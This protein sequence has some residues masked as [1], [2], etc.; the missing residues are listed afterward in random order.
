MLFGPN[1]SGIPA[2]RFPIE[3]NVK[4]RRSYGRDFSEGVL[5]NVS[6]SGAFLK[7]SH[8][9]IQAQDKILLTLNV[10]GR[11]HSLSARVVWACPQGCGL[12]FLPFNSKDTQ[13]IDDLIYFLES[14]REKRKDILSNILEKVAE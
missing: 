4:F 2:P 5:K 10:S 1:P 14:K 6:I 3:L 7:N 8:P 13:I 11:E 9:D 12:K